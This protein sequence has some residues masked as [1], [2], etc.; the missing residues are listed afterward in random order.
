MGPIP[1]SC[2]APTATATPMLTVSVT[3]PTPDTPTVMPVTTTLARGPLTPSPRLM[4][5]LTTATPMAATVPMPVT[6]TPMPTVPV[7][8]TASKKLHSPFF[9]I[10]R[11]EQCQNSI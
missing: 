2:T 9:S 8:T 7:T 3:L 11:D 1:L 4:P 5:M 6:V 10:L